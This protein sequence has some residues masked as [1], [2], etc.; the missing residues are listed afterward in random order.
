MPTNL[1][2]KIALIVAVIAISVFY[3][4]PPEERINLG[5]DLRGGAHILMQVK[6]DSALKYEL[7]LDQS[8]IGQALKTKG[9]TYASISAVGNTALEVKGTDPARRA[10]VRATLDDYLGQWKIDDLGSGNWRITM[11]P[12][13]RRAIE[14]TAV[15]TT[16]ETLRTRIDELGVSERVVQKQGIAGDRILIQLPGIEDPERA[17]GVMQ[18]PAVMEWKTVTYPP[19]VSD[20]GNWTPATTPEAVIA[21][22]GGTLPPDTELYPQRL[23]SGEGGTVTLWWPLNRVSTIV[24]PDLRDARRGQ[25]QFGGAQVDFSLTQ[26]GG[27]RFETATSENIGKKMAIVLG[28]VENK[29]VISAPVI[30]STIRDRGVIEG[31]FDIQGAEDLA[32]KLRSGAIPTDV[33][34]IEE[35][36]V[37]PSLGRD[38]IMAGLVSGIAGFLGVMIFMVIYYRLSGVNAVVALA[39][40]VILVLGAMGYMGATLTL[41]GIAGLILTVGMAVDSNVLI[42]ERIREELALGKTVR[43]A[44]DQGFNRAFMTIVDTHVT[45][46]VSAFFLFS[47]GTGPVKGFAV[48]LTVGLA[49]SMFTAVF[50]SRVIFDIVLGQGRRVETLSI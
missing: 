19:G 23:P 1:L 37:G 20:Y 31:G 48:T 28:G 50:V 9:V 47:Y 39:L 32:L 21:M 45:T 10:D 4:Y 40:N 12:E 46:L 34:I 14:T 11:T 6:T 18:D 3:V 22:F 7:D 8:R 25:D 16:L 30:K 27:R 17:K 42:F 26:D 13:I 2:W 5:L 36:T 15:D 35:R 29:Q 38:S 41:P 49:I 24:G 43:S 33:A 44:V